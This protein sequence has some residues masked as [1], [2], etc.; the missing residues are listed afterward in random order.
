MVAL[1]PELAIEED[2]ETGEEIKPLIDSVSA[3]R[4]EDYPNT[5]N[6][7][8]MQVYTPAET[9]YLDQYEFRKYQVLERYYKTKVPFYRV[10]YTGNG[11]EYVF[12]EMDI[13]RY[14]EENAE[15][16]ENGESHTFRITDYTPNAFFG[17]ARICSKTNL[18]I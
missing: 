18:I 14:M 7:N 13:Q 9:Q 6:K 15:I 11:K 17:A 4:E 8:S 12:N 2:P 1:Y 10:L 16:I 5:Q 3:Y